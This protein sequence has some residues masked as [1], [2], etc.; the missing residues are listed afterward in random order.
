MALVRVGLR[1]LSVTF[2]TLTGIV[3]NDLRPRRMVVRQLAGRIG[4]EVFA[5]KLDCAAIVDGMGKLRA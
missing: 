5:E 2:I 3:H 1:I 4:I